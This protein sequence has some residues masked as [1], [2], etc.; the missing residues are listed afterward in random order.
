MI[1]VTASLAIENMIK[2]AYQNNHQVFLVG[3]EGKVRERLNKMK[4]LRLLAP[5]HCF[6]ER[7]FALQAAIAYIESPNI[8]VPKIN[9]TSQD[10]TLG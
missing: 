2:D 7:L 8:E 10:S 9:K 3:A 5:D 6:K 4:L 1:G